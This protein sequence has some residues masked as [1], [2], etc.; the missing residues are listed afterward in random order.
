VKR[1]FAGTLT[2]LRLAL[3]R[4][5]AVLLG[6]IAGLALM[7]AGSAAATRRLYPTVPSRV[8]AA[9][10][11]NASAATVALYGRVYDPASLGALALIKL[12][13]FGTALVAVV[14]VFAVVRHT[15][16][17]EE[18]GRLELLAAGA[19]GRAAPLAAALAV[20]AGA[21]V[22][23]GAVTALALRGARLPLVGSLTFGLGWALTGLAFTAV[24]AVCAQ[25]SVSSRA[26]RGLALAGLGVAYALRAVGDLPERGPGLTSW[27]SPIGWSQ[28]L[29]PFAGD[30]IGVVA[31][32]LA[33]VALTT[34]VAFALQ[35]RRDLGAGLL[36]ERAGPG[37]GALA[38]ALGLAWRLQRGT[39]L[40]WITAV[41]AMG[42]VFG[43]AARN[44]SGLLS[45]PQIRRFFATLGGERALTDSFLATAVGIFGM[46]A[47]TYAVAACG[48]LRAEETAGHV[49]ILLSTAATRTQLA[50]GHYGVALLGA[51]ALLLA[52]GGSVGLGYG[53][54]T[55]DYA[56]LPRLALATAA[57]VPAAWVM[58][59]VVL[60]LFA[61]A[62]RAAGGAWG[63]LAA[64]I[65]LGEFGA[66]WGLPAW[67][68][69][70][71]PFA[72]SPRLPGGPVH[73]S[74]LAGL[75]VAAALLGLAGLAGWRRRDLAA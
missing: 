4:D 58:A 2:L 40:A 16:A 45:S 26:A 71:S 31:L 75:L 34:P 49:E 12:T 46:F 69:D 56:Q 70:A 18:Q 59:G 72:H 55:G 44:V 11:L 10:M 23:L 22:T 36:A 64:A 43:S 25:L 28:Q 32:P 37:R 9:R 65:A 7:A 52:S 57:Q 60:A 63:I 15:R 3:R 38:S 6:W 47:S 53:L 29:R 51:A 62:P 27:L 13:A 74:G 35:A 8:A 20:G 17:D 73:A 68:M 66:L 54:A 1:D 50:M 41:L 19:V 33:F 61:W 14:M 21:S 39:L 24:A 48:R 67:V 30:R 42:L 5:R